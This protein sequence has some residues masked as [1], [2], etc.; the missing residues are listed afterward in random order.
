MPDQMIRKQ[1]EALELAAAH[2]YS[3][4]LEND[5]VMN[6]APALPLAIEPPPHYAAEVAACM[7]NDKY[8]PWLNEVGRKFIVQQEQLVEFPR[9]VAKA[10]ERQTPL[11][12]AFSE[13]VRSGGTTPSVK[14]LP[15]LLRPLGVTKSSSIWSGR[16][17]RQNSPEPPPPE[18]VPTTP[19]LLPQSSTVPAP[20]AVEQNAPAIHI[21]RERPFAVAGQT[22][23]PTTPQVPGAF[24]SAIAPPVP[25]KPSGNVGPPRFARRSEAPAPTGVCSPD[26]RVVAEGSDVRY[27]HWFPCLKSD[28]EPI[29][30]WSRPLNDA[31]LLK[32]KQNR[33]GYCESVRHTRH[34]DCPD[35]LSDYAVNTRAASQQPPPPP[36]NPLPA[37]IDE[38]VQGEDGF[39]RYDSPRGGPSGKVGGSG[40]N[41]THRGGNAGNGGDPGDSDASSDSNSESSLPD[42]RKFLGRRK[43]HGNDARKE[44]YN[45]WCHELAEYLQ[46]Q[47]KGKKSAHRPKKPEKLGVDPFK[48]DSTDTQ[49]LIQDCEIKLDYFRES[50]GKNWDKVSLVMPLLQGPAKK[51]YQSIH[52]YVSEQG[53]RQEGIPF[54]PKNVLRTSEVFRQR[55]VSGFGGH[56]D[57]HRALR[58]WNDLT[59]M[60]DKINHF[61]DELMRLAL[62]LGYSGN[63]VKDKARLGITTDLPNAWALKTPL[64]DEYVEYINLLRQTGHQLEECASFNRT[65]TRE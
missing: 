48:G 8:Q 1:V 25:A 14:N 20:Q 65:V 42:P 63:F 52:P 56:S 47:C 34:S 15:P 57:R 38:D 40:G 28:F 59:I 30:I 33:C 54:N 16:S 23:L 10:H 26:F 18:A 58:E 29:K 6:A 41:L 13:V 37:R 31:P 61:W 22:P 36:S 55:L 21:E 60:S 32:S 62:Q 53:A 64:P 19:S 44:K 27:A 12:V 3:I 39:S 43:S 45:R 7:I 49:S 11:E 4:D 35:L 9:H 51:W 2:G 17:S 24:V 46:K 5:V 50:L